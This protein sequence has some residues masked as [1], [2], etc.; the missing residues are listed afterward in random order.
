VEESVGE[1]E[2]LLQLRPEDA[3]AL[4][5]VAW[6]RATCAQPAGRDARKAIEYAERARRAT[7]SMPDPIVLD[8]LAAAY[9]EGGRFEDAVSTSESAVRLSRTGDD[10]ETIQR[11][12]SHLEQF[13]QGKPLHGP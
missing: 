6:I 9:A 4:N 10:Q 13:R 5:N 3:D 8:T 7:A 1:Y 2:A 11:L 12:E